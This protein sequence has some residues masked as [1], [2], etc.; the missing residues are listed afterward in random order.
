MVKAERFESIIR[1]VRSTAVALHGALRGKPRAQRPLVYQIIERFIKQC[2]DRFGQTL[3]ARWARPR[4]SVGFVKQIL[5]E[6]S[7]LNRPE[8]M[9]PNAFSTGLVL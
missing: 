2:P 9:Q 5:V 7:S 3:S 6:K 4:L 8:F 1:T